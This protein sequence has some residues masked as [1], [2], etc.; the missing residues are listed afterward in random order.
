MV[1]P[2][3]ARQETAYATGGAPTADLLRG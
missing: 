1:D 2:A 3:S